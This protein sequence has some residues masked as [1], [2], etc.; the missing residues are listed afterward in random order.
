M[1]PELSKQQLRKATR[2]F[3]SM[4]ARVGLRDVDGVDA[5]TGA[6][7]TRNGV[8]RGHEPGYESESR[9][10]GEIVADPFHPRRAPLQA[11]PLVVRMTTEESRTVVPVAVLLLAEAREVRQAAID[12]FERGARGRE[13]W[14]TPRTVQVIGNLKRELLLSESRRWRRAGVQIHDAVRDD[15]LCNLQALAQSAEL[16]FDEGIREYLSYVL[17]PSITAVDSISMAVWS[18]AQERARVEEIIADAV[19]SALT[20]SDALRTYYEKLGHLPLADG[21]GM[22]EVLRKWVEQPHAAPDAIWNE[23]WSWV[24]DAKSPLPRYH[25]CVAMLRNIEL[26]PRDSWPK[27]FDEIA[28]ILLAAHGEDKESEPL[29]HS[30]AWRVRCELAK[31]YFQHFGARLRGADSER[32]AGLSWWLAERVAALLGSETAVRE[33]RAGPLRY[34]GSISAQAWH[35][36]RPALSP[37]R[38]RHATTGVM[39]MWGLSLACQLRPAIT[40]GADHLSG[41]CR[42]EIESALKGYVLTAFPPASVPVDSQVYAFDPT[43]LQTARALVEIAEPGES[44]DALFAFVTAVEALADPDELARAITRFPDANLADQVITANVLSVKAYLGEAP[45][46][47][48]WE[49]ILDAKWRESV[50]LTAADHALEILFDGLRELQLQRNEKW[51]WDMPHVYAQACEKTDQPERRRLLFAMVVLSS[52]S[53]GTVSAVERLVKGEIRDQLG[54]EVKYWRDTLDESW[55]SAPPQA[56]SEM[57][58]MLAVLPELQ[59]SPE[60]IGTSSESCENG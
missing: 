50:L 28:G 30:Q 7:L 2:A 22:D 40:A 16:K 59:G 26:V 17:R 6:I 37:S 35:L 45:V 9:I 55:R 15:W 60:A 31:H 39:S 20:L 3:R 57:R 23:V 52:L 12:H 47:H 33:F 25:A 24:D 8:L 34:E 38:L 43:V 21:L 51:S 42:T 44:R 56:G 54:N 11:G 41:E 29:Q 19:G 14:V 48:I 1:N 46:D 18:P 49:R 53:A 36:A 58:A 5:R 13:P 27:L 32:I 4:I 10:I